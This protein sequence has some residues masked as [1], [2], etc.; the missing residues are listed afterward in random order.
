MENQTQDFVLAD[1][2]L[3][4]VIKEDDRFFLHPKAHEGFKTALDQLFANPKLDPKNEIEAL[5]RLGWMFERD[6]IFELADGIL[7]LLAKDERALTTLGI[8]GGKLRRAK[9]DFAKLAGAEEKLAAPVFGE[10]APQGSLKVSS[11]LEPGREMGRAAKPTPGPKAN[12]TA[13]APKK[14]RIKN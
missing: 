11:F 6:Q 5:V 4:M 3:R 1:A 12:G 13:K 14:R 9:K 8:A 10:E 2:V 7:D